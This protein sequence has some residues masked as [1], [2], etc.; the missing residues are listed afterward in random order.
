MTERLAHPRIYSSVTRISDLSDGGYGVQALE[1]E[2]WATGDYVVGRVLD[3]SGVSSHIE[4]PNGRL[5][6][7]LVGQEVVGALGTRFATLE[8][9]GSWEAIEPD[10]RMDILTSGGLMGR[11]TSMSDLASVPVPTRYVGH[12]I[13]NGGKATMR[14]HVPPAGTAEFVTPVV[15][16]IG[17]SMSAGKTT[18]ARVVT[19]ELRD[20]GK[21]VIGAK[22][23]GAGRYSDVL[24]MRDAGAEYV[25]D[26][27]DVGL[28]STCVPP[29][30]FRV[31]MKELLAELAELQAD[32]VVAEAGASPLEPY[33]G[34]E[35][36]VL[37]GSNVRLTALA[38]S[39]PYAVLGIVQAFGSKPDFVTGPA[40]N[41]E[42]G[43]QLVEK[44]TGIPAINVRAT[45][46]LPAIRRLLEERFAP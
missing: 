37:L 32:I 43:R 15:L 3:G 22:F 10:G 24:S 33:N 4:L 17:T 21:V 42:A 40:T 12:V 39:D 6:S 38:A 7:V 44:L 35:A 45:E 18:T 23:T 46:S 1:R 25:R 16:V 28:P 11:T 26:F 8:I 20:M 14:D 34:G 36:V 9:V 30:E 5:G 13:V 27:V 19:R 29:A 41:T 2:S 31:V